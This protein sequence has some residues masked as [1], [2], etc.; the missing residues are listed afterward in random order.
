MNT[1][2]QESRDH[3][4][5]G[6]SR[7]SHFW[8][9]PKAMGAI[10]GAI[11]LSPAPVS[12]DELVEQANVSKG[13]VSTNVRNLERLGMIHKH[14]QVGDRKDYY[15]AETDF[16]KIIRGLLREREKSE[17]DRALRTVTESMDILGDAALEPEEA[18]LAQF[19]QGRMQEMRRFFDALDNLV[20]MIVALDNLRAS[21][22]QKLFGRG[23]AES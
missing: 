5:Q 20:A 7:I 8:G 17:F 15:V 12:L 16:W 4:I 22:L 10:F 2:I 1:K 9:F 11:Y 14:L 21:T 18:E 6:M 23:T 19:Y 3:F 13:A